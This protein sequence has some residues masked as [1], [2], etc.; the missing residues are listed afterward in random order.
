MKKIKYLITFAAAIIF[1]IVWLFYFFPTSPLCLSSK[2]TLDITSPAG[3]ISPDGSEIA[4]TQDVSLF[5]RS[6]NI[7]A[8]PDGGVGKDL[9]SQT[10]IYIIS[11]NLPNQPSLIAKISPSLEDSFLFG[12]DDSGLYIASIDATNA[13]GY[14]YYL[15]NLKNGSV[16]EVP[17]NENEMIKNKFNNYGSVHPTGVESPTISSLEYKQGTGLM[18]RKT[19]GSEITESLL[20]EDNILFKSE[21][22][23]DEKEGF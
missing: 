9:V 3:L 2:K 11:S 8:L 16:S 22:P 23:Y 19:K 7:C 1:F 14:S 10:N 5:Q 20:V 15:V 18:L 4:Y 13:D 21:L 17:A 12:W 6:V